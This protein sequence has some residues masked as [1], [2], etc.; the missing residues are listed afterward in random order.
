MKFVRIFWIFFAPSCRGFIHQH[1]LLDGARLFLVTAWLLWLLHIFLLK[2]WW[3]VSNGG[4]TRHSPPLNFHLILPVTARNCGQPE[5]IVNGYREGDHFYYP[6]HVKFHC[7]PG[8]NLI[9]KPIRHCQVNRPRRATPS[10]PP[11]TSVTLGSLCMHTTWNP[12]HFLL[13]YLSPF[14]LLWC[15]AT[16]NGTVKILYA[17]VGQYRIDLWRGRLS[18]SCAS[19]ERN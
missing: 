16:E 2:N 9:G 18:W 1:S 14:V 4:W 11:P 15:S 12:R 19:V 7:Y 3:N 17:R 8:Y 10:S 6:H 13:Y 5:D